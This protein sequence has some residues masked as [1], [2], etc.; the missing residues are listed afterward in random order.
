M[1]SKRE[2]RQ[3][4]QN[5]GQRDDEGSRCQKGEKLKAA[6]LLTLRMKE[7]TVGEGMQV[8]SEAGKEGIELFS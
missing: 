1:A 3:K 2:R 8:V 6:T 5:Q 7:G 4:R